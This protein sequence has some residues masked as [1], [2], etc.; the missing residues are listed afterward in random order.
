[1]KGVTVGRHV[2]GITINP[3]EYLLD[4]EGELMV[5]ENEEAAKDFLKGK[6]FTDDDI[7]WLVFEEANYES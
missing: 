7:Y 2:D 6:G 3:L 1:M 5:F 4:D